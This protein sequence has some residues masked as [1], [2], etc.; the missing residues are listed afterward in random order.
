[1]KIA[2]VVVLAAHAVAHLVG[3]VVPWRLLSSAEL[4]YK[5]TLLA[6]G[7]DLGDGGIRLVGLLWLAAA[8]AFGLAAAAFALKAPWAVNF[9]FVVAVMS[10]ALCLAEWPEARIGAFVNAALLVLFTFG[11]RWSAG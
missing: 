4:P 10:M 7:V 11:P 6:G 2:L 8:A 5:T 3:F 9:A 1:M